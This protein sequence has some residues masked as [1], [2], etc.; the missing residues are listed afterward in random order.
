MSWET[1]K[2]VGIIKTNEESTFYC[3]YGS[4]LS[5][6]TFIKIRRTTGLKRSMLLVV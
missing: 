1:L 4:G 5:T 6:D 3:N 2:N